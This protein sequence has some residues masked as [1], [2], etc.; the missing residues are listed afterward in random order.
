LALPASTVNVL[1]DSTNG[2][3]QQL[4]MHI[5]APGDVLNSQLV[6][7]ASG[8][9]VALAVNGKALDLKTQTSE[10]VQINVI[11][12]QIDGV[13]LDLTVAATGPVSLTVQDRR[14]GLP[15]MPGVTIAPRPAWMMTAALNDV[16]DSTI[17]LR[18]FRF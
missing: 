5:S 2:G 3:T 6:V 14:L 18:T 16:A 7:R 12:P 1:S 17:V 4:R 10:T 13:M 8:P 9:F 15:K 11:G